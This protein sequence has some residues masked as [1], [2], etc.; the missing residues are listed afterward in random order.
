MNDTTMGFMLEA[1]PS[2]E[3]NE[4]IVERSTMP[5]GNLPRGVPFCIHLMSSQLVGDRIEYGLREFSGQVN[6]LNSL[7]PLPVPVYERSSG[8]VS[9]AGEDESAPDPAHYRVF[10]SYC[11]PSK[12]SRADILEME[13]TVKIIRASLQGASIS[14]GGCTGLYRYCQEMINHNPDSCAKRRQLDPYSDL[15]YQCV[16][17]QFDLESGQVT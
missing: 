16:E 10:F 3:T 6:R 14:G 5:H 13:N 4:S 8:T 9:A 1:I 11:S 15:N 2:M 12:K 7:T 17:E